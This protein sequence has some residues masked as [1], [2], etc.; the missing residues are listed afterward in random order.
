MLVKIQSKNGH[1]TVNLNRRKAIRE[2]C[3]NCTGWVRKEVKG[4]Q[5]ENCDIYP[6][7][8]GIG[9]QDANKRSKAIRN[10]CLDYCAGDQ[11]EVYKCAAKD[12]SLYAFRKSSLDNSFKIDSI[13]KI[14]HIERS[15]GTLSASNIS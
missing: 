8:M 7:R 10:H 3:L 9:K 5:L 6:F 4:C 15:Q 2:R 12:C 13:K 1:E 14:G 11:H